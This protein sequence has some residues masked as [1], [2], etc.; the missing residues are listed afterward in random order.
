MTK[1]KPKAGFF[2]ESTG[3]EIDLKTTAKD[4]ATE[5]L[6]AIGNRADEVSKELENTQPIEV[7]TMNE[8]SLGMQM[9][10][11]RPIA[12]PQFTTKQQAFRFA[13]WLVFM[14]EMLPDETMD[15]TFLEIAEAIKNT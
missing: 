8:F 15:H 3:K 10:T 9:K 12:Y 14:A 5:T 13:A 11:I 2:S 4:L 6:A 7:N 1:D